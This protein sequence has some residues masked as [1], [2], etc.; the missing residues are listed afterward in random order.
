MKRMLLASL[1]GLMLLPAGLAVAADAAKEAPYPADCKLDAINASLDSVRDQV[2]AS[3]AYGHAAGH[4]AKAEKDVEEIRKQLHEGCRA[5]EKEASK[6][7]S[8]T[9]AKGGA[10]TPAPAPAKK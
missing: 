7:T 6:K 9:P 8:A 1:T 4:Y 3:P 5:W 2:K 10:A